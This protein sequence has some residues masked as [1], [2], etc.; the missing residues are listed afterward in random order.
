MA[1]Q[2]ASYVAVFL[3]EPQSTH[4]Y[5]GELLRAYKNRL[6]LEEDAYDPYYIAAYLNIFLEKSFKVGKVNREYRKFKFHLMLGIK[7][8][9]T[10]ANILCGKARQQRKVCETI[11]KVIRDENQINRF[12]DTALTCLKENISNSTIGL[13]EAHRSKEFTTEYILLL[14]KQKGAVESK[15]YIKKGDIVHCTVYSISEYFVKVNIKT[16]DV[17]NIGQIHISRLAKKWVAKCEDE[18]KIGDIFQARII[19]DD[20]Y[21]N[22]Y[23]WYLSKIL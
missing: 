6:F 15:D 2:T 8:L 10:N 19:S 1:V 13:A 17:R 18:V 21:E 22:K 14:N 12:L 16:D 9:I 4:R 20:F 7:V 11:F 5:Y 23:G 3:N